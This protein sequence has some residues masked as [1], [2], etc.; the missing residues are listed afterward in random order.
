MFSVEGWGLEFAVGKD[1][2]I[3][4]DQLLTG[5]A[6]L[7]EF[8]VQWKIMPHG[9]QNGGKVNMIIFHCKY[10]LNGQNKK[11]IKERVTKEQTW[12]WHLASTH[13]CTQEQAHT[14]T[15]LRHMN[16]HNVFHCKPIYDTN[17]FMFYWL[18][19]EVCIV[20]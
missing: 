9:R 13:M 19:E 14:Y 6:I 15:Q 1:R 10:I 17:E 16:T 5:V 11:S 18:S 7:F 8:Q 3:P 4:W 12:L 20:G 2:R